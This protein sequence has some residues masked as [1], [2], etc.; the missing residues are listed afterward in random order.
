MTVPP[1][2]EPRLIDGRFELEAPLG[3]GGMADVFRARDLRYNRPVA[4]KILRADVLDVLGAERF[5]REIAVTAAFTHPHILSLLESG[6]TTSADGRPLLYYVMP[7]IEGESMRDR[8]LQVDHL[9]VDEAVRIT[10]EVLEALRYA[11]E[12]GV[13][14]RDI[15]PANI[16]LS[17]GH[18]VVAD[19][20]VARPLLVGPDETGEQPALTLS[21]VAVGTPAYMSPEQVFG[22]KTVDAR[23]DLYAAGCVLYEMLIGTAPFGASTE[24]AVMARKMSGVFVAPTVMRPS[25]PPIIDEIVARA[26]QPDAADR[27]QDASAFLSALALV[28]DPTLSGVGTSAIHQRERSFWRRG[29]VTGAGAIVSVLILAGWFMSRPSVAG[30]DRSRAAF[31]PAHVAVLPFE[32]LSADTS[33]AFVAN[34][35][36]TDLIDELAQIDA[37]TVVSKNGT[38][39]FRGKA[40]GL[41]SIARALSVGSVITGDVRTGTKGLL[42]SVRLVDGATGRQLASHDASGTAREL[43]GVRSSI[44]D[45]VVRFLR[46]RLGEQVRVVTERQQAKNAQAWELVER[47]RSLI[48]GELSRSA[49]LTT[50]ARARRFRFADSLAVLASRLDRSWPEPLV[51]RAS[52]AFEHGNAE[53]VAGGLS[54]ASVDSARRYWRDAVGLATESMT[55]DASYPSA[56]WMRGRA[57]LELWRTSRDGSSDSLRTAAEADLRAAVDRRPDLA[58]AWNDLGRLLNLGGDFAEAQRAATEALRVDEYQLN[59]PVVISNLQFD[60]LG[61]GQADAAERW[62]AEGRR[63][64]PDRPYFI[65][66]ELTNVGWTASGKA[67]IARAWKLLEEGERRDTAS[68]LISGWATRRLFVA[69][70]AARAGL[71]D[72]ALAIVARTRSGAPTAVPSTSL[73][74]GEAHVRALLGQNDEAIRLLQSYL[75][76]FPIQRRQVARMPWFRSLRADPRFVELTSTR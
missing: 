37:L 25:L 38:L 20:G 24:Q 3:S 60:A 47:V 68:V 16:L 52:V 62:C 15:K 59:A 9:S 14:H 46:Q 53:Q 64:Y 48:D 55:R 26:I 18:A 28:D 58:R 75:A 39:P 40:I 31:D 4:I 65:F 19:F 71:R 72:S 69:A 74:Y 51:Q 42:V 33:L 36:T 45:D 17:G 5:R 6:E 56:Y 23:C 49:S 13:I 27:F 34:G 73:D 8:L 30:V 70:V 7:L 66:C 22:G 21:G 41:D 2:P 10:R 32:N 12:H 76:R 54:V 35:L 11:H 63:R 50:E 43:L 57:R 29:R 1:L 61:S 67:D 44:I